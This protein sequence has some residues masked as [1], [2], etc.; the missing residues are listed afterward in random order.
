MDKEGDLIEFDSR[1]VFEREKS[2]HDILMHNYITH[3]ETIV[4]VDHQ[5]R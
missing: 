4:V 5:K 3:R 2:I 1:G